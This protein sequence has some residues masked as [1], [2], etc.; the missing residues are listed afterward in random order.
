MARSRRADAVV[1][2]FDFQVNAAIVLMIE[3]IEELSSLQLE[4]NY[5][6]IE[7]GLKD[8]KYILAQAKSVVRS[9]EDFRN[10]RTNL[11]KS[12]SSLSEGSLNIESE[13]L[14]MITNSPN[15]FNDDVSRNIFIGSAHRDFSSLPETAKGLINEYVTDID[16]PLDLDK[17]MIQI[18][19]FETDNEIE[20]YKVVKQVVDDFIGDLNLNIPGMGK[21]LL[22]VWHKD[23]FQNGTKKNASIKLE[24]KDV[25]W[26]IIII[27]TDLKRCDEAFEDTFDPSTYDEIVFQYGDVIESCSE[28]CE[29]FIRV[30]YDYNE[31]KTAGKQSD[32]CIEF[33]AKSGRIMLMILI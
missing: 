31:F 19:P 5:E 23:V 7:L 30:L 10:V 27:A 15:P 29:F 3:N 20:R 26:P 6:D 16:K 1:F 2:G 17:F 24:K 11:K 28:R 18:L 9:S 25:I 4:G 22:N 33:V 32:K 8:G 21:Q 12:L 13:K 14:I